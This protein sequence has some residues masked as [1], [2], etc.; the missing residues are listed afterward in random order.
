VLAVG[1][2]PMRAAG[3]R[4]RL[5]PVVDCLHDRGVSASLSTFL[6][7]QDLAD[8][9]AGGPRRAVPGVHGIGHLPAM[10]G[11]VARCDL[12]LLHREA[13]PLNNLGIE[14]LARRR[15]I[16]IV[17]DVDDS[18]WAAPNR[19]KSPARGSSGK[20]RWLARKSAEV[21]AGNRHVASW[22]ERAGAA[23][24]L[25]V[26]T[27][28]PVPPLLPSQPRE[29]D[30]LVWVGTPSTGPFIESL[31]GELADGLAGWRVLVVG[32]RIRAPAGVDVTQRPWSPEAEADALRRG[33]VGLYP[34]DVE[35]PTT[36][37]KSA[38]KSILFM[39]HGIPVVATPTA[40]NRD[41]M[42]EGE[43]GLFAGSRAQWLDALD[44]LRDPDLRGQLGAAG[45]RQAAE[46]FDSAVWGVR[47]AD[48]LCQL[49][50]HG[51]IRS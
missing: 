12:L 50:E 37:G 33:S 23:E 5:A 39:A 17:W 27:T 11:E 22:A 16:P 7:D 44:A 47:L 14:R 1:V 4:L 51:P 8:W 18:L 41:V 25:V 34:L 32:A 36:S 21:W 43:Q 19:A 29:D 42:V 9:L 45:H 20:Y 28:V 31:L 24:V 26:P 13:L 35:H 3:T 2:H 15:G 30:L 40:S 46:R 6:R 48:R 10:L 38:L 49:L